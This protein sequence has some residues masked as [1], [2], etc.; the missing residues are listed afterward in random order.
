MIKT[1]LLLLLLLGFVF[2][3]LRSNRTGAGMGILVAHGRIGGR[4]KI[5][6]FFSATLFSSWLIIQLVD[7][8]SL[9]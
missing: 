7:K 1:G 6:L 2:W 5:T 3:A 4:L 9:L 8:L